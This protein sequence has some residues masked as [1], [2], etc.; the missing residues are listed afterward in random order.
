MSVKE[1]KT[2]TEKYISENWYSLNRVPPKEKPSNIINVIPGAN[3][4][5][6]YLYNKRTG[7]NVLHSITNFIK[8]AFTVIFK[9]IAII[10]L[11]TAFSY[12]G[13]LM[14]F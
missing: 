4:R 12:L 3:K 13:S 11:A 10:I 2:R 6:V 14:P 8:R 7:K 9:I 1:D 5:P